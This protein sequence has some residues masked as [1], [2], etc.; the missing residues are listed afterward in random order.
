MW[1]S[2][3]AAMDL[4][5]CGTSPAYDGRGETVIVPGARSWAAVHAETPGSGDDVIPVTPESV[6]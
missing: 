1:N 2:I 6:T 3:S 5:A 4:A